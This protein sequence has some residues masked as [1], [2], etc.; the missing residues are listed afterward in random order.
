[1]TTPYISGTVSVTA[2]NAVVTGVGT[3][4]ATA[5]VTGGMFG[6]DSANG[7]PV[8]IASI[9]SDTQL[10]L[11]KPW[12][13][14]TAA[15]QA[16]WIM[17]DTSY[18][19]Q[20][21]ANATALAQIIN[22]LRSAALAAFAGLTPAADK[23]PYFTSAGAATL[24]D[25]KAKGRDLL[26]AADAAAAWQALGSIPDQR[27]PTRLQVAAAQVSTTGALD[28]VAESGWVAVSNANVATVNGPPGASGGVV[29]TGRYDSTNSVQIYSHVTGN[30]RQ[31]MR[32]RNGLG[33]QPWTLISLPILGSVAQSGGIPTGSVI[34]R[35]SNANGEYVRLAD[36]TQICYGTAQ[37]TL[38][39]LFDSYFY[40]H[41]SPP[42][43]TFPA[44]FVGTIP[45]VN[46]NKATGAAAVWGVPSGVGLTSCLIGGVASRNRGATNMYCT[47]IGRWF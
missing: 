9:D 46:V 41:G 24:A 38:S 34:E 44:P 6:L 10:T 17:R 22:E 26:A 23:V 36:G 16:Y 19:Q 32:F 12:R 11:A 31:W 37:P 35:G 40:I 8:P 4:W 15:T 45:Q 14:T 2:G 39:E 30:N 3:G 29:F 28:D 43:W 33:W 18:G 25:M 13:G 47:A 5:L 20:T 21:V 7:N 27:L 42:T 1:M